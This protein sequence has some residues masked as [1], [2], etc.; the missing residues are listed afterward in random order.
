[1]WSRSIATLGTAYSAAD[2]E[3]LIGCVSQ[4][5]AGAAYTRF[6]PIHV[7]HQPIRPGV[8]E[9]HV[10]RGTGARVTGGCAVDRRGT[11]APAPR[12]QPPDSRRTPPPSSS[13][14]TDQGASTVPRR[15][16]ECRETGPGPAGRASPRAARSVP[17][18]HRA[19][20]GCRVAGTRSVRSWNHLTKALL[21]RPRPDQLEGASPRDTCSATHSRQTA[22][23]MAMT[24]GPTKRPTNP[25]AEM[26]PSTA[27][28]TN[29]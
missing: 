11:R 28:K 17:A 25:K 6:P 12:P 18:V 29:R 23:R 13:S 8:M 10:G 22:S 24:M 2:D 14:G 19:R 27:N 5:S 4:W 9:W 3:H 15:R 7:R 21:A 1:M 16:A 26:P 20:T